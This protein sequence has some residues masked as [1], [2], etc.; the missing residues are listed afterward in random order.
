MRAGRP[1]RPAEREQERDIYA[2]LVTGA[3]LTEADLSGV[4]LT[5]AKVTK[6]QLARCKSLKRANMPD[7]SKQRPLIAEQHRGQVRE[8]PVQ[9]E[10]IE[11]R[12][13]TRIGEDPWT[14]EMAR[15]NVEI[16]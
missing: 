8:V 15:V 14:S 1:K 4:D 13:R 10:E 12:I 5:K 11:N 2:L 7:G 9:H 6:E 3:D 16:K